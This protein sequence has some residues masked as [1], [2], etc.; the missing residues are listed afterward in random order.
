[1]VPPN[2]CHFGELFFGFTLSSWSGPVVGHYLLWDYVAVS[3]CV[4]MPCLSL[5]RD[6]QH[7]EA[8]GLGLSRNYRLVDVRL[9]IVKVW[10]LSNCEQRGLCSRSLLGFLKSPSFFFF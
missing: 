10:V 1:M 9:T 5:C 3:R 7:G 4:Q 6:F 2:A 8:G